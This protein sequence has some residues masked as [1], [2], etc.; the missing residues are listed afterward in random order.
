MDK[1]VRALTGLSAVDDQLSERQALMDGLAVALQER[2]ARFAMLSRRF[3]WLR[4]TLWV[5]WVAAPSSSTCEA[6]TAGAATCA[7]HLS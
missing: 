5:G 2:R 7:S 1:T 6:R 4:T 3:F